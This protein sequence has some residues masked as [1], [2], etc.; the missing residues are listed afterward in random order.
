MEHIA[1]EN[2]LSEFLV[3]RRF[4]IS[5]LFL[6]VALKKPLILVRTEKP[7]LE[8]SG[9]KERIFIEISIAEQA[10]FIE[11]NQLQWA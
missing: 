8:K 1:K 11:R 2:L 7:I 3:C 5:E 10:R 6:F 4:F 9:Q